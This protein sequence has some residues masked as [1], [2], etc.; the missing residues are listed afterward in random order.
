MIRS[1]AVEFQNCTDFLM[2]IGCELEIFLSGAFFIFFCDAD[3]NVMSLL[4]EQFIEYILE[5]DIV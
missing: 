4:Y 2:I 3:I 5:Y 1:G